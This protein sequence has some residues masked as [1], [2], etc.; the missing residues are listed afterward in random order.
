MRGI[1]PEHAS[2]GEG[3]KKEC[4]PSHHMVASDALSNGGVPRLHLAESHQ[5]YC[6]WLLVRVL[7]QLSFLQDSCWT[8]SLDSRF[9]SLVSCSHKRRWGSRCGE[10]GNDMIQLRATSLHLE[11]LRT[12]M[13]LELFSETHLGPQLLH[14]PSEGRVGLF[15][16]SGIMVRC[17]Y[18]AVAVCTIGLR[19]I[20]ALQP[21]A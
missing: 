17:D 5:A 9:L 4:L 13:I 21:M 2:V 6:M 14:S 19:S 15:S 10:S 11:L 18:F 16:V 1:F 7:V 8:Q 12:K 20:A 3:E